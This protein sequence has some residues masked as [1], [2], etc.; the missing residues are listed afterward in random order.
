MSNKEKLIEQLQESFRFIHKNLDGF[1]IKKK[2][3]SMG[4]NGYINYCGGLA[5]GT[6]AISG[7]GGGATLLLSAPADIVNT[8]AQQFRVTLA[9]IYHRTGR[10]TINFK[11]FMKIVG[12]S[13]GVEVGF[14]GIEY[15]TVQI[16][17][18]I[19]KKLGGRM[20]GRM[21]PLLGGA[22]GAGLNFGFIK[23]I[24]SALL[25]LEGDIFD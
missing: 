19:L 20:A 13:V 9:V 18:V 2:V 5:A 15:L 17:N 10:Y 22:I 23:S 16:A 24:G 4:I 8:I 12:L 11:E 14:K 3:D 6:G 21:I 1:S 7:A 25:E